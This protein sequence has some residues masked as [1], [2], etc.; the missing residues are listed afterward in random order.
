MLLAPAVV[1]VVAFVAA[2][3]PVRW[4]GFAAI[5]VIA[6]VS[7]QGP[8]FRWYGRTLLSTNPVFLA[9]YHAVP[10]YDALRIP[11]RWLLLGF[12]GV[13]VAVAVSVP[14]LA[15]RIPRPWRIAAVVLLTVCTVVEQSPAPWSIFPA[16]RM[17]DEPVYRWVA[18]QPKDT[19]ILERRPADVASATTQQLE[20]KRLWY[21]AHHLRRRAG[22]DISPYIEPAYLRRAQLLDGVGRDPK[23][24]AAL[25]RLGIDYVLFD[26]TDQQRYPG[27]EPPATVL[28]RLDADPSSNVCR[29]GDT[30]VYRVR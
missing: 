3:R 15:D 20:A 25:R 11:H 14:P 16:Y 28:A 22:G 12:F 4:S 19:V 26:A 23:A 10:G 27:L 21:S 1:G 6:L 9:A 2:R 13:A 30:T 7:A 18:D 29:D 8:S 17:A 5:A 24:D